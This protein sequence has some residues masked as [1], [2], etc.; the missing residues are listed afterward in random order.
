MT[1]NTF[2]AGRLNLGRHRPRALAGAFPATRPQRCWVHK[3]ATQQLPVQVHAAACDKG[4][5]GDLQRR[6]PQSRREGHR[7]VREDPRRQVPQCCPVSRVLAD[8]D[9]TMAQSAVLRHLD[10]RAA[11]LYPRPDEGGTD[12]DPGHDRPP[13][14]GPAPAGVVDLPRRHAQAAL[15]AGRPAR[16]TQLAPAQD[17]RRDEH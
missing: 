1:T 2:D 7:G 17:G 12:D 5:A 13:L 10:H 4:Y 6:G 16:V 11:G 3:P 9:Q 15:G 14:P 8:P